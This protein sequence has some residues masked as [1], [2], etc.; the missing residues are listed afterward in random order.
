MFAAVRSV[1]A[2]TGMLRG[3]AKRALDSTLL[4][5]AVADQDTVTPL[6]SAVRRARRVVPGAQDV[7]SPG[8]W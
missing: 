3:R 4:D 6:I 7:T 1:I 8:W 5:D 2:A